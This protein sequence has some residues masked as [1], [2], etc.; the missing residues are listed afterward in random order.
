MEISIL[1]HPQELFP[2]ELKIKELNSKS[3]ESIIERLKP[4]LILAQLPGLE[5]EV[6]ERLK[7]AGIYDT[8]DF[9]KARNR[10]QDYLGLSDTAFVEFTSIILK[11]VNHRSKYPKLILKLPIN[12][13]VIG[14]GTDPIQNCMVMIWRGLMFCWTNSKGDGWTQVKFAFDEIFEKTNRPKLIGF[15]NNSNHPTWLHHMGDLSVYIKN[16][17]PAQNLRLQANNFGFRIKPAR[18]AIQKAKNLAL[19]IAYILNFELKN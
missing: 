13:A 14:I 11:T 17:N 19:Q 5:R 15:D 9:F 12:Y 10:I 7:M 18:N 3:V 1:Q 8:Q 2:L 4:I 16:V 6:V